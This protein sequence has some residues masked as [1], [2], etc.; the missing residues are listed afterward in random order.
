MKITAPNLIRWSG[1]AAVL[2]GII[3]AGIQPIHPPDVVGSVTT[4]SWAIII[5]LKFAMCFLFLLGITGLYARQVEQSGWLGLVGFLLFSLSWFLQTGFVFTELFVLP[6][7]APTVPQF[8]VSALGV[9]NGVPG[10]M[11]IGAFVPTYN[12]V[13]IT[14]LL[15]G[16]LF[17]IAIF[18]ARVLPRWPAGLLAITA[19][20]TPAAVLLPHAVQRL[21]AVPMGI[22]LAWLGYALWSERRAQPA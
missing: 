2:G 10:E 20:V 13:G 8:V 11:D 14:Y 16:L 3:F 12:V 19:L 21:A 5:T 7:L 1:L 18:R 6:V 17:G 15:G 9:A 4:G 22:A